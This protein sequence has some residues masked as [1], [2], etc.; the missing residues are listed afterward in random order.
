MISGHKQINRSAQVAFAVAGM[1][2]MV[3]MAGCADEATSS[4]GSGEAADACVQRAGTLGYTVLGHGDEAPAD[5]GSVVV[6]VLIQW[7]H[8]GGVDVDCRYT[9]QTGASVE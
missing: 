1:A 3:L 4:A 9:S 6:P 8:T 2:F 7:G 5:D